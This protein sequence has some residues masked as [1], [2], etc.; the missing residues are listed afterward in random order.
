ME[1]GNLKWKFQGNDGLTTASAITIRGFLNMLIG[2]LNEDDQRVVVPLGHGDPSAFPS[3]RTTT[4]AEDG[5]VD[6][7]RSAK[8]NC[9]SPPTGILPARR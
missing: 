6:A 7:L 1:T 5:I 2:N 8:Y 4:V 3:F 9:Y